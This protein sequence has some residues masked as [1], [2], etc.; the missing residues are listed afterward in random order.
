MQKTKIYIYGNS[1]HGQVVAEIA[2]LCGYKEIVFLD[3]NKG[4][5]FDPNLPKADIIIAIG[6]N[7]TR[8]ILQKKVENYGFNLVSLIHPSS[9][10][11]KSA[12]IGKGS[13]IM[14]LVVI[15]TKAK[16][17]DGVILNSGCI[18]EHECEISDFCHISPKAS[19]AGNVKIGNLTHI[20]IG[21]CVIQNIKIGKNVV[22][23]AGGVVV[24]NLEDN[25]VFMGIPA[26]FKRNL[27]E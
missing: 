10:I 13:V 18:I 5:K 1:G 11:S 6:D 9:I 26:K 23:A 22:V 2:S 8:Q 4:L 25:G 17:G 3:D 15:N 21:S 24:R 27:G 20:G 7:K 16:I 12:K 14:P 19:L